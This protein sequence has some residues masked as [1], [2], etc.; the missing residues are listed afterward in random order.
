R[1]LASKHG[2][3]L[4]FDE[5]MTGFRFRSGSA[6][7]AFGVAPDMTCLGKA[8]AAGTVLRGEQA[9]APANHQIGT[10]ATIAQRLLAAGARRDPAR[11]P[12]LDV[13][14]ERETWEY[15]PLLLGGAPA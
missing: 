6:A 14:I 11:E 12:R 13:K 3:L 1:Q 10:V 4:I 2:A 7:A 9:P 8:L 15:Y 5:I